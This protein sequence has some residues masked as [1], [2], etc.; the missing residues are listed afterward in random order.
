MTQNVCVP[1]TESGYHKTGFC[2][3]QVHSVTDKC[4]KGMSYVNDCMSPL[5]NEFCYHGFLLK[6]FSDVRVQWC[7]IENHQDPVV[8]SHFSTCPDRFQK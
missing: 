1:F 4:Q 5:Q 6:V 8:N 3:G 7:A 2:K